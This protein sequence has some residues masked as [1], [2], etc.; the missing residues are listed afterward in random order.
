MQADHQKQFEQVMEENQEE[1]DALQNEHQ[2][3]K[4][5]MMAEVEKIVN[6]QD[7]KYSSM[8]GEL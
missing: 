6:D 2:E 4:Q 3:E 5:E 7:K 8:E 1:I